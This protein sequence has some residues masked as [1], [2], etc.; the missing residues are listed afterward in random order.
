VGLLSVVVLCRPAVGL[1]GAQS[2]GG[3]PIE[4]SGT[5]TNSRG[6]PL[7]NVTVQIR[8]T[9][10]R[11][12]TDATGKYSLTA[13]ADG[14]L[15]FTLIGH[16]GRGQPISGHSTIN[17][18]MEDAIAT[19]PD[20]VVTG[21]TAQRRADITGAVA[22]VNV[23]SVERQSSASVLQRLDGRVAGVTVDN[24]GSPGSRT[25]VRIRGISSF[26]NNDPLYIVDGTPIQ[27]QREYLNFL[28]PADI[29]EIQVLKDAS[30]ASIYGARATASSLS[31]QRKAGRERATS[32]SMYGRASP[33]R[34]A[35]MTIS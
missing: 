31:R 1:Q 28:N 7:P 24:S 14:A 21:Y 13:P 20:V 18:V 15:T 8:G 30:A 23:E 35:A 5:V 3:A 27:D 9:E 19:L 34:R 12:T 2:Q 4:V 25:T 16:R 6:A 33:L 11:T 32:R 26:Q 29:G 10:I 22:T 17:V